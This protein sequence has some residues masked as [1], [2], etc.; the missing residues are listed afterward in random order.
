MA[1]L[2]SNAVR[3]VRVVYTRLESAFVHRAGDRAVRR[4]KIEGTSPLRFGLLLSALLTVAVGAGVAAL[5]AFALW[6]LLG[7][8]KLAP[9]RPG[10]LTPTDI[11]DGIK[12]ALT[13]VGGIGGVIALVVAYRKQRYS[14]TAHAREDYRLYTERFRAASEQLGSDKAAVRL[15]GAYA[16][17]SLADDWE[18][19]R[20][21]C[22][23]VLC[24]YLRMPYEPPT[25]TVPDDPPN[26]PKASDRDA[27][28]AEEARAAAIT[29][30][31]RQE[32]HALREE[33]QVRREEQQVR[34]TVIKLI[35][36]HLRD[37]AAV[38]WQGRDFDFSRARFD[39]GNL[40]GVHIKSGTVDFTGARFTG[41]VDFRSLTVSGG[42]V[43]FVGAEFAGGQVWFDSSR[44][45]LSD[46]PGR[47]PP[48]TGRVSFV[49][50]RFSGS[51]VIFRDVR[52]GQAVVDFT[53]AR[54]TAGLVDF[55]SATFSAGVVDFL[56][57]G[58]EGGS[59]SFN[60]AAFIGSEVDFGA[61]SFQGGRVDI[62]HP[63][64]YAVPPTFMF[65]TLPQGLLLPPDHVAPQQRAQDA[66]EVTDRPDAD[67]R[68][69]DQP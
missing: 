45:G 54:V 5:C 39:G 37:D 2:D 28:A 47:V 64:S 14:E 57:T 27:M 68:S 32:Q 30:M 43:Y 23:D 20:Q 46:Q 38:T 18:V 17:A 44:F 26:K 8:P 6:E 67:I 3:R 29:S 51:R 12:I 52:F 40:Q 34:R 9:A 21:T 55:G 62:S 33:Q 42:Q 69:P 65:T 4:Y 58:F 25:E 35:G 1:W 61:A 41:L 66:V 48:D 24:A 50:A 13:V 60:D 7:E 22:I 63:R 59:V 16:M 49:G 53:A 10:P 11:Y 56:T 15:A 19:E 36:A 31:R